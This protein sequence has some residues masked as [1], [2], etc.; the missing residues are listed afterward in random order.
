[1]TKRQQLPDGERRELTQRLFDV[2]T[3]FNDLTRTS[4]EPE[5]LGRNA[6]GRLYAYATRSDLPED[7][8]LEEM[9][10]QDPEMRADLHRLLEK[11]AVS[12]LPQVAAA[13]SGTI[14][15]REGRGCRIRFEAS[16]A[17]P[18]QTYVM[19]ELSDPE[20]PVPGHLVVCDAENRCLK[21]SLPAARD[22]AIQILLERD[23][24]LLNRL[25]DLETEVFLR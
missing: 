9:L 13:S 21:C 12:F 7:P 16:R 8:E 15:T 25:L 10:E 22:G 6:I 20:M 24:A 4:E 18:S 14:D 11:T 1:M 17:E 19:I 2:L 3:N 23:S 5:P